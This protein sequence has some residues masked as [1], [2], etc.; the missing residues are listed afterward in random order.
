M[1][2]CIKSSMMNGSNSGRNSFNI[3]VGMG[4]RE[5]DFEGAVWMTFS[6]VSAEQF[7]NSEKEDAG[8]T[9]YDSDGELPVSR[10]NCTNS[11]I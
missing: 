1:V 11:S 4:S 5:Q 2:N 9:R 3:F 7:P 6:I 10:R 8:G